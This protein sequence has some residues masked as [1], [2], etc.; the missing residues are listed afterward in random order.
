[1]DA[2]H[3]SEILISCY[4]IAWCHILAVTAMRAPNLECAFCLADLIVMEMRASMETERQRVVAETIRQ[5]E[6][7]KQRAVEETKKKQWCTNCGKEALFYCC[8]NTS[9]CDYPCQ[10][11]WHCV[12]QCCLTN[13]VITW[14]KSMQ[15]LNVYSDV[16]CIA[17]AFMLIAKLILCYGYHTVQRS[18]IFLH[19]LLIC[20]F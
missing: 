11:I 19:V 3:P 8:W 16:W 18:V 10:V 12:G 1:M 5:C 13:G 4:K 20:W 17:L 7:E 15:L 6:L 9:Y 2:V 14:Y